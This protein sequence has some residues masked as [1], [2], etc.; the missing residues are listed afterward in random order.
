MKHAAALSALCLAAALPAAAQTSL[1]LNHE[2]TTG[3]SHADCMRTAGNTM[4]AVGLS[5]LPP[6]SEAAWG[7]TEDRRILAA[8]YCLKTR[9]VALFVVGG[10]ERQRTAPLLRQ[11]I[12]AWRGMR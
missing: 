4:R 12:D 1:S 5:V 10:P 3:M 2:L 9:D 11:L 7:E 6:T 8:I